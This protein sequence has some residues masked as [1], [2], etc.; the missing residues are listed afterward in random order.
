MNNFFEDCVRFMQVTARWLGL[1]Y[2]EWNVVLFVIV[3]PLITLVLIGTTIYYR[4][5]FKRYR[6]TRSLQG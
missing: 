4:R 2:E 1:T 3:H 6:Q 5:K